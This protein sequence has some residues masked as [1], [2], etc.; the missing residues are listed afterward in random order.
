MW[1]YKRGKYELRDVYFFRCIKN[2]TGTSKQGLIVYK[3]RVAFVCESMNLSAKLWSVMEEKLKER[4]MGRDVR[5]I[6][7]LP[8]VLSKRKLAQYKRCTSCEKKITSKSM[9]ALCPTCIQIRDSNVKKA[10]RKE[11]DLAVQKEQEMH[12]L[13][14]EI[15]ALKLQLK[16]SEETI[17]SF[18]V[19]KDTLV[20]SHIVLQAELQAKSRD[21]NNET[22]R[23]EQ[24]KEQMEEQA[25]FILDVSNMVKASSKSV[26][27]SLLTI[28]KNQNDF[29]SAMNALHQKMQLES[30]KINSIFDSMERLQSKCKLALLNISPS[31]TSPFGVSLGRDIWYFGIY[32]C[33][34]AKF[35]EWGTAIERQGNIGSYNE[36]MISSIEA[37][38]DTPIPIVPKPDLA[39]R[40]V[41]ITLSKLHYIFPE[42]NFEFAGLDIVEHISSKVRKSLRKERDLFFALLQI[43][44]IDHEYSYFG[45]ITKQNIWHLALEE[46]QQIFLTVYHYHLNKG[47]RQTDA[48]KD[49]S[50]STT[51]Y[52][53]GGYYSYATYDFYELETA[54]F[55]FSKHYHGQ[56]HEVLPVHVQLHTYTHTYKYD[57]KEPCIGVANNIN[58]LK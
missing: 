13:I 41:A 55:C 25:S 15:S 58:T 51:P 26:N 40:G 54:R 48:M 44:Q 45:N 50:S 43:Y 11:R 36:A 34:T 56:K 6:D 38:L 33:S 52:A 21:L 37:L 4:T 19:E 23:H 57:W 32:R 29:L 35:Q 10:K 12:S 14:E 22:Y 47:R 7:L 28:S 9:V 8:K 42:M 20:K 2:V 24:M 39:G 18:T 27:D 53:K 1:E 5:V 3:H 17:K 49:A 30:T 46:Y 16:V 31:T